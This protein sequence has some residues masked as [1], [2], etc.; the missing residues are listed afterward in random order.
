[1]G[2]AMLNIYDTKAQTT[3]RQFD[4]WREELCH[5]FVELAAERPSDGGFGGV[6]RQFQVGPVGIVRV[7]ADAHC[8]ARSKAELVQSNNDCYFANLQ[9]SGTAKTSQRDTARS[10]N[11][12]EM[13]LIDTREPF[14]VLHEDP[15]DLICFMLPRGLLEPELRLRRQD[16]LPF[17]ANGQGR[18]LR[19][20]A[21]AILEEAPGDLESSGMSLAD[22]LIGL[23]AGSINAATAGDAAA[24]GTQQAERLRA[25]NAYIDANLVN[26][27]LT[28]ASAVDRFNLSPR[29]LQK[30]FAASGTTFSQT[31]LNRRLDKVASALGRRDWLGR[32][33]TET[34]FL[35]G[36]N[37]FSY[38]NRRFRK[39]FGVSPRDYR[40]RLL[41][42]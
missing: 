5:T 8:V 28:L 23:V 21:S 17:A 22:N 38:F 32:S 15:F 30:L 19:S 20:F 36:F 33:I 31:L 6:M 26:P 25:V 4:Y 16:A 1:M 2:I 13:V 37:D 11:A 12:G 3:G 39:R 14:S 27:E 24:L 34:A 9:L 10:A 40:A 7:T 42:A 18:I 41:N 29:Y 35:Y